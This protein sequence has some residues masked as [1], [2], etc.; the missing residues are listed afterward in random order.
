MPVDDLLTIDDDTAVLLGDQA[1]LLSP[2]AARLYEL[3]VHPTS[4]PDLAT[5]LEA[6][7]GAPVDVD[8]LA[9]TQTAVNY[10]VSH[11][12]LLVTTG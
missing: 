2:L 1:L 9:A 10:L 5:S 7:F 6:T 4:L 3:C 11:R 12:L 8:L